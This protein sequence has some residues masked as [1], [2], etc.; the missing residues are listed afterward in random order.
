MKA[1]AASLIGLCFAEFWLILGAGALGQPWSF[2][3]GLAGTAVILAILLTRMRAGSR[4]G[5]AMIRSRYLIA[6]GIEL[7]ALAVLAPTLAHFGASPL[8]WPGVGMIVGLHFIGLWWANGSSRFLWLSGAMTAV[9]LVAMTLPTQ[10]VV[11][12]AG[13][14]SASVLA[15][16][17]AVA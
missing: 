9:N 15:A 3:V 6:V 17:V 2:R 1:G 14:A 13:L 4:R 12:V 10:D 11:A 5:D 8:L 7:V 16:S